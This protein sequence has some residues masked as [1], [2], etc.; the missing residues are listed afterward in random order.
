MK[1]REMVPCY[2]GIDSRMNLCYYQHNECEMHIRKEIVYE[3]FK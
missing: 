2:Q 3:G 1:K